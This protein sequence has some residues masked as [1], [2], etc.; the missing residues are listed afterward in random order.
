LVNE[1]FLAGLTKEIGADACLFL[2]KSEEKYG[3]RNRPSLLGDAFEAIVGALYLDSDLPTARRIVMAL[4]GDLSVRLLTT[5][6]DDNPKGRLQ[7]LVQPLHGNTAL[8]YDVLD[9]AGED[10][11]PEYEVAVFLFD[12]RIG[13]G[14]GTSK[15]LA[16][17]SAAR[18]AL[19]S[20][21]PSKSL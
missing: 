7:E 4:Y 16:E 18:A 19:A 2:G 21:G 10:H 1:A 9:I 17:E 15:K 3:G 11:A 6:A 5:E 13:T 20:L 14:C 8:R 12:R